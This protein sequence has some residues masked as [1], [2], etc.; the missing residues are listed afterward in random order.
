MDYEDSNINIPDED[1]LDDDIEA[2]E[3][4]EEFEEDL[5]NILD[6]GE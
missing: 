5:G 6:D 3:D 2:T 4:D 1:I